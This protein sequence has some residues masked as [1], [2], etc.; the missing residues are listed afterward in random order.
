MPLGEAPGGAAPW[1]TRGPR[2]I[3]GPVRRL[4]L[5]TRPA[6]LRTPRGPPGPK[7][8]PPRV[9]AKPQEARDTSG[10]GKGGNHTDV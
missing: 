4:A 10:P 3:P 6:T 5:P 8:T 2:G 1:R 9:G 7:Q